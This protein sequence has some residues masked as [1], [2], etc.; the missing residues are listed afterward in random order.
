MAPPFGNS[1]GPLYPLGKFTIA[2]PG[3]PIG[4]STTPSLGVQAVA[5]GNVPS[6]TG[7]GTPATGIPGETTAG[8]PA[9]L[10]CCGFFLWTPAN[11]NGYAYLCFAGT[12]AQPGNKNVPNSIILGL[13]PGTFRPFVMPRV[14]NVLM[15][16]MFVVDADNVNNSLF[17]TA[18]IA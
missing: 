11:N 17:V 12:A 8:L 5:G 7:F 9:Q 13:P 16:G 6:T 2:A 3:T 14:V 18:I 15:P 1:A 10:V 4:L